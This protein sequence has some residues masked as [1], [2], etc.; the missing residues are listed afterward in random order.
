MSVKPIT[1][2]LLR[3]GEVTRNSDEIYMVNSNWVP[4]SVAPSEVGKKIC[5]AHRPARR[6]VESFEDVVEIINMKKEL[7][8]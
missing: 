5:L 7:K 2:R 4:F 8:I 1:Y 3:I 6:K